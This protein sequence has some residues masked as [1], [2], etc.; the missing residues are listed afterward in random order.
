MRGSSSFP[1]SFG[2][3]GFSTSSFLTISTRCLPSTS[4]QKG[5]G[6]E[7]EERGRR[8]EG[9]ERRGGGE[10]GR[11][12]GEEEEE[13]REEGEERRR[14]EKETKRTWIWCWQTMA[15]DVSQTVSANIDR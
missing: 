2:L 4:C 10:E 14:R 11:R 13:R 9:E 15:T 5:G 7:E 8:G 12:G 1:E 6:G 3:C